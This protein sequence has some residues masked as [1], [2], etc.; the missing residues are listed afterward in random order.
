MKKRFV[1][2]ITLLA[3]LF[4]FPF[5]QA[6][7]DFSKDAWAI[8]EDIK[9]GF[10]IGNSMDAYDTTEI[11]DVGLSSETCWGNPAISKALID[12]IA[13]TGVNA[14]RL[15]VTWYNHMDPETYKVSDD[16]MDRVEE[17]VSYILESG[18]YCILNTHHDT[19]EKGWLNADPLSYEEDKEIFVALWAQIAERFEKYGEKLL[20]EGYNEILNLMKNWSAP[21]Y[22]CLEAANKLNQAFVDTVRAS[23]GNNVRRVLII[24]TYA[25]QANSQVTS[26]TVVPKDTIENRIIVEAHI[27]EPFA[28]THDT[29]PNTKTWSKPSID[30]CFDNLY[31]NF[32]QKGYPVL[33]GEFGAVDKDNITARANW[34]K[35]MVD[36]AEKKGMKCF[37]WDNGD[38]FKLISRRTNQ[39]T[40]PY[41][42]EIMVTEAMGGDYE[43]NDAVYEKMQKKESANLCAKLENW[44]NWINTGAGAMG[45]VTYTKEGILMNVVQGGQNPWDAQGAYRNLTLEEGA[46]YKLSFDYFSDVPHTISFNAIQNYGEYKTYFGSSVEMTEE[47]QHFEGEFEMTSPTDKNCQITFD[48]GGVN[49]PI[50][51]SAEI[52]NLLLVKVN[53]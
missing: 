21:N 43:L 8:V 7:N 9:C 50:P 17:V 4:S 51:Y 13:S 23:G 26:G 52:M 12:A 30:A 14:V 35:Y 20:F 48:F 47:I 1:C 24:T 37:W 44:A 42:F 38:A 3:I 49:A 29:S 11:G 28:F 34:L 32:V 40:E 36:S 16:W 15:P 10:N 18:M 27:Y 53:E 45:K 41:L 33:I 6:E 22:F 31:K 39:I 46:I 19:G 5:A 25:A 2:L